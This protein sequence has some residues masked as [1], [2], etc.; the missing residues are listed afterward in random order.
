M[1]EELNN[2]QEI[3]GIPKSKFYHKENDGHI[4][5]LVKL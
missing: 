1:L 2:E 3:F 4:S 5:F